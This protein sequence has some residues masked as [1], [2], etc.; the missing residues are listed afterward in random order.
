ME[1]AV[2]IPVYNEVDAIYPHFVEIKRQLDADGIPCQF[3][4]VDD[5]SKD[6]SWE[7]LVRI[8]EE[9]P[10]AHA[11]KFSRNFG[12]ETALRAGIDA[13]EADIYIT[14]DSDLQHP[15]RHIKPMIEKLQQEGLDIVNGKKSSRGKESLAYKMA[16]GSFYGILK[17]LSGID[18]NGDSDFK[19][20]RR[21]VI[22]AIRKMQERNVFFR[23]L[24]DWVGFKSGDYFFDVE[25]RKAGKTSFSI[26]K[27]FGLAMSAITG[28]TSKPL[29]LTM[30]I[31][32][33]FLV[34]AFI[35]GIHTIY[36]FFSGHAISGFSTVILLQLIIG[37]AVL[38]CLGLIGLYISRIYDEVKLRPPYIIEEKR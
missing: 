4:L 1:V 25:E 22:L 14:M 38:I 19:V 8:T 35:L 24:V 26:R 7:T 16:A 27:L 2:I 29:M 10:S 20:M 23:G 17:G 28:Y 37:S 5:G 13:I 12:K 18:M 30:H 6:N 34:F 15:P 33:L 31:G 36:N 32:I 11:V 3:M 9:F 21:D